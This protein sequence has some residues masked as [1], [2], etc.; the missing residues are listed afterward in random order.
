MPILFCLLAEDLQQH[1]PDNC[2]QSSNY[3][4]CCEMIPANRRCRCNAERQP[5]EN[6][7][8]QQ[9]NL[10]DSECDR[11]GCCSVRAR[12]RINLDACTLDDP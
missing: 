3:N 1:V 5:N 2:D 7:A 9:I 12:K 8:N 10:S 6:S 4:I 11:H